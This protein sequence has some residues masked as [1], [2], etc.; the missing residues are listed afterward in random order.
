M[1]VEDVI[2]AKILQRPMDSKPLL[3]DGASSLRC[4]LQS[5]SPKLQCQ[6]G[7]SLLVKSSLLCEVEDDAIMN[8]SACALVRTS[9]LEVA[10]YEEAVMH[11]LSAGG[12]KGTGLARPAVI[13]SLA[14]RWR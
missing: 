7:A 5:P 11:K 13:R 9:L 14:V 3:R 10:V 6:E 2:P 8:C 12:G 1:I 4:N